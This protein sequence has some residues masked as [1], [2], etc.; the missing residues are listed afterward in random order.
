MNIK[1]GN[2]E[3]EN[4]AQSW[5]GCINLIAGQLRIPVKVF[6]LTHYFTV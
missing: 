3:I 1:E 5:V 4:T 6:S 2:A